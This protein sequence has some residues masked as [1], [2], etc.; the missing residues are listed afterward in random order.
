MGHRG[1]EFGANLFIVLAVASLLLVL[2]ST[3]EVVQSGDPAAKKY[4]LWGGIA[5][6]LS[7]VLA[8]VFARRAK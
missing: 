6:G 7:F 2:I 5:F 1:H 4:A 8:N 3:V